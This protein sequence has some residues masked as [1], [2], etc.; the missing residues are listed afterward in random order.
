LSQIKGKSINSCDFLKLELLLAAATV[1]IRWGRQNT[2]ATSLMGRKEN[3][4]KNTQGLRHSTEKS[5][6]KY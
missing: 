6:R 2:P 4:N 1:I 3:K 5:G